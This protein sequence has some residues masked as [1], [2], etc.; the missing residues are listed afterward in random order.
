MAVKYFIAA[1]DHCYPVRVVDMY[2]E[3][4]GRV[5]FAFEEVFRISVM[6][7]PDD[8]FIVVVRAFNGVFIMANDL[9]RA[10]VD[11]VVGK[12]VTYFS[13]F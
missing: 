1:D 11:E 3:D 9:R 5:I 4:Y 13:R 6:V 10:G 7:P 2:W 12:P 8:V